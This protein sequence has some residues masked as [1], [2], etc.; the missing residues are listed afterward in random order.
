MYFKNR[1]QLF[2]ISFNIPEIG[3]ALGR[4]VKVQVDRENNVEFISLPVHLLTSLEA[5]Y[6]L[7]LQQDSQQRDLP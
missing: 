2:L 4:R 7:L 5:F 1:S 3:G 6:F